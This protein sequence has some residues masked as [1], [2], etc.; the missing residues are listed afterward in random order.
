MAK[1]GDRV[2]FL[3]ATGGGII[4]SIDG[5][6][7]MVEDEDGF[8]TPVLLKDIVVVM[9]AGHETSLK[10]ASVMFDQK[11][12]DAG[13]NGDSKERELKKPEPLTSR[14]EKTVETPY[15]DVPSLFLAFEPDDEKRITATNFTAVLL[16]DSNYQLDFTFMRRSE[17]DKG[18]ETVYRG[19]VNPNEMIDLAVIKRDSLP[20]YERVALQGIFYKEDKAFSLLTPVACIKRIDLTKFHKFHCFQPRMYFDKPVLEYALVKKGDIVKPIESVK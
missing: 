5:K 14:N 3:N 18:W 13:K 10:S 7:A 1:T 12:F 19:T 9:P 2:R 20:L 6:T 17:T 4:K 16:N 11:A 8:E 15:G